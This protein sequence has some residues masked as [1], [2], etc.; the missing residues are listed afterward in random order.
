MY[1]PISATPSPAEHWPL[2]PNYSNNAVSAQ[3]PEVRGVAA[4]VR[5]N[6]PCLF[7]RYR[8]ASTRNM[9]RDDA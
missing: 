2:T 8:Q 7:C 6:R 4:T 1:H 5:S 9:E 3:P